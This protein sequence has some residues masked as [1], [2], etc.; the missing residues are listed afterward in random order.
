MNSARAGRRV[1]MKPKAKPALR[2]SELLAAMWRVHTK[3]GPN[4]S[5]WEICVLRADN[6]HGKESFGWF[7]A[8]KILI[9]HNGGQC[10]DSVNE[11]IWWGL[12]QLATEVAAELNAANEKIS[13]D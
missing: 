5:A 3:G 12:L 6:W 4:E 7:G 9:S 2:S 11:R 10:R 13:G 8:D 1:W